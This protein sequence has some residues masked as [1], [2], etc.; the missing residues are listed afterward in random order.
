[1]WDF[2]K[3]GTTS[4]PSPMDVRRS[5]AKILQNAGHRVIL[6]EDEP[7]IK[8]E[9]LIQK[10]LRLHT[11][12][13]CFCLVA[14]GFRKSVVDECSISIDPLRQQT[15]RPPVDAGIDAPPDFQSKETEIKRAYLTASVRI[16]LHQRSFRERVLDAYRSTCAFC[17][18]RHRELLDAA[19]IIPDSDPSGDPKITNGIALCKIHHAAFDALIL[20]ITPDYQIQVRRDVMDE[21]DG[22]MLQYGLKGLHKGNLILPVARIHWPDKDF[23]AQRYESFRNGR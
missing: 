16:R 19:H 12:T 17:R 23:L 15:F 21:E 7:D 14:P 1:M 18:L 22:P 11:S 5:I 13:A 4:D 8:G 3:K 20:G 9:D 2:E 6:M 10:F